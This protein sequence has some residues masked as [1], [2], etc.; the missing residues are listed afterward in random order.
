VLSKKLDD[1]TGASVPDVFTFVGEAAL[2]GGAEFGYGIGINDPG[3]PGVLQT[4][5]MLALTQL[6]PFWLT[7]SFFEK[8]ET[9]M[10]ASSAMWLS[11]LV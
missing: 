8:M 6:P 4:L 7:T 1:V 5:G 3:C 10:T 11:P 9:D 2:T